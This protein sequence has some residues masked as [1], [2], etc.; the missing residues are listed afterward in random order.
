M[1]TS[2]G[3]NV[4]IP[5]PVSVANGG[6]GGATLSAG[7]VIVGNGAS[8][9]T[10]VAPG[11]NGN[12]L[13]VAAG[14]WSS[15][16][17]AAA[18]A[19]AN[20]TY[21]VQ[22]PNGSLPSAQALSV[23]ATGLLK[24]TTATGILSIATGADLPV[25]SAALITSGTLALARGGTNADL[26]A[27][28]GANQF[29]RQ[30]TLGGNI[31]V[32]AIAAAD[33]ATALT[34]STID[35]ST[36][37]GIVPVAQGGAGV[38]LSG[39]GGANQFVKQSTLGGTLTVAGILSADLTTALASPPA[40][41]G[42]T[43][44]AVTTTTLTVNTSFTQL[45]GITTLKNLLVNAGA[46][47]PA[48]T[49][50]T[51]I[52]TTGSTPIFNL[53]DNNN[54][55]AA[56]FLSTGFFGVGVTTPLTPMHAATSDAGTNAVVDGFTVEHTSSGTPAAGFGTST[57]FLLKSSTTVQ[58]A[59]AAIKALWN[60][61]TDASRA[62]DIV[63]TA[64]DANAE[65]EIMRGRANGSAAMFSIYGVTPVIQPA[66]ANQAVLTNSTGGTYDGTLVDVGVVFSQANINNNFTDIWTLQNEIRT[67]LIAVGIMKGSA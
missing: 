46:T 59:A 33:I 48:N 47:N 9:V 40:I 58:R 50:F 32:S 38:S 30:S 62:P 65:R 7:A 20:G 27:T 31:T 22:V 56:T 18:G 57:K 61:A 15:A 60:V 12:V 11:A 43:A 36:V 49:A 13:V 64:T 42:T 1:P 14:A 16:P 54:A 28:G 63:I 23:L 19:P 5:T 67:A 6:T 55:L 8:P 52:R 53:Y 45:N 37:T 29:L 34:T 44:A 2:G 51:N 66:S 10:S 21:I 39:T 17:P 25:H 4:S 24:S 35:F 26:S 41:G 3:F